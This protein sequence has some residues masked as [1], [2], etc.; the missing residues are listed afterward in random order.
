MRNYDVAK[1]LLE[2][3]LRS[4]EGVVFLDSQ[5][6]QMVLMRDGMRASP[7]SQCGIIKE[8]RFTFYDQVHP[9]LNIAS[10]QTTYNRHVEEWAPA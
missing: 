10:T 2:H 3:G 5:D 6:R 4:M 8:K 1:Y 7:L 9:S